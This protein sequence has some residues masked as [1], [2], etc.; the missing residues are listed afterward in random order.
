MEHSRQNKSGREKGSINDR[1]RRKHGVLLALAA[2]TVVG[3]LIGYRHLDTEDDG[4]RP[5]LEFDADAVDSADRTQDL[6]L[7]EIQAQLQQD[8]DD[9][10]FRVQIN[11]RISVKDQTADLLACN[12]IENSCNMTVTITGKDGTVYYE[13]GEMAPGD[14][15]LQAVLDTAPSA[16]SHPAVAVFRALD[17]ESGEM[18]GQ[19][20][21]DVTLTA[22]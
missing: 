3:V 16:G 5:G 21:A 4:E 22:E 19:V 8:A 17:P 13:S 14:R 2:L 11:S 10:D 7:E 9:S 12:G 1:N 15:I 18:I 20:T 6:S